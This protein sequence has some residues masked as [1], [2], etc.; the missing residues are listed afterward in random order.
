MSHENQFSLEL[1][2][3]KEKIFLLL[4]WSVLLCGH[5]YC[6]PVLALYVSVQGK[7]GRGFVCA[8]VFGGFLISAVVRSENI[9]SLWG[10]SS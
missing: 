4:N 2:F 1:L 8:H 5:L 10:T 3:V 7:R 9:N 6:F